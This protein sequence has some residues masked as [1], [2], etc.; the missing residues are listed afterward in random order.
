[1]QAAKEN[2]TVE[3]QL[4]HLMMQHTMSVELVKKQK[5]MLNELLAMSKTVTLVVQ[6]QE[7]ALGKH[8]TPA[9][10]DTNLHICKHC[11]K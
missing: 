11:Q 2:I 6:V 8:A 10:K 4:Q 1:M 9:S 7:N 3:R 5:K